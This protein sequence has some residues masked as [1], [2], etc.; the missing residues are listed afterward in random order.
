M[1]TGGAAGSPS[2]SEFYADDGVAGPVLEG[3]ERSYARGAP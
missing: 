2:R 1:R 3:R